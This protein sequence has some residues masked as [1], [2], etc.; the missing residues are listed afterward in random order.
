MPIFGH[1]LSKLQY[2]H[3]M[4]YYTICKIILNKN[5]EICVHFYQK[6]KVG[7]KA[8]G[9]DIIPFLL[10]GEGEERKIRDFYLDGGMVG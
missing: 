5:V 4:E 3:I 2:A 10:Q 7:Y 1:Q 6:I 8:V 9:H